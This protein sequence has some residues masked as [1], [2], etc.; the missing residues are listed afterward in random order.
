MKKKSIIFLILFSAWFLRGQTLDCYTDEYHAI[1]KSNGIDYTDSVIAFNNAINPASPNAR[2][3]TDHVVYIPV[4]F[5]IVFNGSVNAPGNISDAQIIDAM[6]ILNNAFANQNNHAN[7]VNCNI[8]FC[9]AKTDQNNNPITNGV[10]RHYTPKSYFVMPTDEADLKS[11]VGGSFPPNRYL[12]IWVSTDLKGVMPN[13]TI[14]PIKGYSSFPAGMVVG[15]QNNSLNDGIVIDYRRVGSIGTAAN[16]PEPSLG[17]TLPHEVGHWLGLFHTFESGN[18]G[19]C[20]NDNCAFEGDMICDTPPVPNPAG[21]NTNI[22][23]SSSC[24]TRKDC[25]FNNVSAENYMEYNWDN[26][27]NFFSQG[28][29]NRMRYACQYYRNFFWINSINNPQVF[30]IECTTPNPFS[31]GGFS[32]SCTTNKWPDQLLYVNGESDNYIE[33]CDGTPVIINQE[34]GSNCT[35]IPEHWMSAPCGADPNCSWLDQLLDLC[36]CG[37]VKA[38]FYLEISYNCN[39]VLNCNNTVSTWRV[40]TDYSFVPHQMDIGSMLNFQFSPGGD[41]QIKLAVQDYSGNWHEGIKY[42]HFVSPDLYK[43]GNV[44][45]HLKATNSITFE[46][47]TVPDQS[48][49]TASSWIKILPNSTVANGNNSR[50][51]LSPIACSNAVYRLTNPDSTNRNTKYDNSKIT[52][53]RKDKLVDS[54]LEKSNDIKAVIKIIPNPSSDG[55][56]NVSFGDKNIRKIEI[57]NSMQTLIDIFQ[58]TNVIN[59][60]NN[61][62]G[63]YYAIITTNEG[64]FHEKLLY[65]K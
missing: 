51:Y 6:I 25:D 41:Y 17:K 7:G 10:T 63:I 26:C 1:L 53:F 22:V 24:S 28:Q 11:Y 4:V 31:S 12:N 27:R 50:F 19:A 16:Q 34:H 2:V 5:H 52:S 55:I 62:S 44:P 8:Q 18:G 36:D 59:L 15:G 49:Y 30:P 37:I 3:L 23:T 47:A 38:L 9:L 29:K 20:T 61:A 14:A 58:N 39:G 46:N 48:D 40:Y 56:F 21:V 60:N 32:S 43:T 64:I 54:K 45:Q 33:L 57:Y 13:N 65:Y 35:I 42:I